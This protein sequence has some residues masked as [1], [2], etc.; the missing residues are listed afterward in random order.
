[1][2]KEIKKVAKSFLKYNDIKVISHYD[3]DGITSAAIL[4]RALQ[5]LDKKFSITIIKQLEKEFLNSFSEKQTLMFLDLGSS[6]LEHFQNLKNKVF[7]LDHHNIKG[8]V[9]ENVEIINP[10]LFEEEPISSAELSYLFAKELGADNRDLAS[11]AVIG[12]VG[13]ML[14]ENLSK[15]SN[16]V[17]N[18]AE[19]IIKKG[20]F[21]YPATRPL[22]KSLE[23]NSSFFIPGVTGNYKGVLSLLKE[24]GIKKIDNQYK[25]L[26]DLDEDETSKLITLIL[27][28]RMG[29]DNA[30]VIGNIYLV[31]FFNN[32]EDAREL[33]AMINACS[34][35][36]KTEIALSLC[37][38]NKKAR[39]EAEKIYVSYKQHLV[40]ALNYISTTKKIEGKGYVIINAGENVK[41]TIIGTV[42]GILSAS[43]VYAPGTVI[44]TM[45]YSGDKIKVSA[46]IAGG[47]GRNV[48]EILESV[49]SNVGG[50]CG[51]HNLAS[52]CL[53]GRNDEGKFIDLL[54][55]R[56]DIE[57]VKI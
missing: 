48:S 32:L 29:S 5:R 39:K 42:A 35:L 27:I 14:G 6:H 44:V 10:H 16:K 33:S 18:D 3:T 21:I 46:R 54:R 4:S 13:D 11:L 20:L 31:K 23:Y 26:V 52:G 22:N 50:E 15:I 25:S 56:L 49:V 38:G 57:F 19:V 28:R 41:D 17:I 55:K 37:L 1:M 7:I 34:R 36:G 51:G 8:K 24:A 47:K 40:N 45:A 12:M 43:S 2:E 53:I 9:P 30:K